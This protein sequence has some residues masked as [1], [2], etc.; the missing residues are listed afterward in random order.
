MDDVEKIK[1]SIGWMIAERGL[2][3]LEKG[4][5]NTEE[6]REI[7]VFTL[8][9]LKKITNKL[10]LTKFLEQIKNRWPFFSDIHEIGSGDYKEDVEEEVLDGV[11]TLAKHGKIDEAVKLAKSVTSK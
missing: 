10:D 8:E 6:L 11:L 2:Q 9:N 1:R 4:N 7:S 3:E 5:I